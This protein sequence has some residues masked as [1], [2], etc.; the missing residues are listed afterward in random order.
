MAESPSSDPPLELE[1]VHVDA[2]AGDRVL[3]RLKGRWRRRSRNPEARAMLIVEVEGRR[4]RFPAIPQ[5]RRMRLGSPTGWGA[6]FALPAWLRPRLDGHMSLTVGD[7]IV[8]VPPLGDGPEPF[9]DERAQAAEAVI[10]VPDPD[11]PD[12]PAET[13]P[14]PRARTERDPLTETDAAELLAEPPAEGDADTVAALRAELQER[15]ASEARLRG[16][17]AE[18]KARADARTAGQS[19]LEATREQLRSE[20]DQLRELVQQQDQQRS[21]VESRA[22]VL[23]AELADAQQQVQAA[24]AARAEAL[25][26][27]DALEREVTELRSALAVGIVTTDGATAETAALRDELERLGEE[28]AAAREQVELRDDGLDEAE[29]LL[30]EARELTASLRER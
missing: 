16:E 17:L 28:L 1:S 9:S 7:A 15:A 25:E 5:P 11:P 27:R 18:V 12:R 26:E 20:L 3:V 6:S 14:D 8:P 4:H 19:R 13:S 23:A 10:P 2:L 30:T 29:A 24:T 21:E 22:M